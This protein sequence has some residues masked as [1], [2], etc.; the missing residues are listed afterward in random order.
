ML[1]GKCIALNA[2][3]GKEKKWLKTNNLTFNF[4]NLEKQDQI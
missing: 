3:I 4:K 2:D 1:G